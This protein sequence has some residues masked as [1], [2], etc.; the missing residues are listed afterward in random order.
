MFDNSPCGM[1][2]SMALSAILR[3]S[4]AGLLVLLALFAWW[5]ARR[6]A[7][8]QLLSLGIIVGAFVVAGVLAPRLVPTL[9]KLTSFEPGEPLAASWAAA[10]FGALV[11]GAILLRFVTSRLPTPG[12][13]AADR[14]LGG[15]LGVAKGLL[16]GVVVG[17][18]ILG[19]SDRPRSA[20]WSPPAL[21]RPDRPSVAPR[22]AAGSDD[23]GDR[24]RG[25]LSAEGL[26]QG[27]SL[28]ARW[29]QIP[30]WV[31]H[32]VDSVNARITGR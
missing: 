10:L 2:A 9:S 30:P 13:S 5:G 21:S 27:A 32:Q 17:Y 25:S 26:A 6:G 15:L 3:S 1:P 23:L 12:R 11:V 19:T 4:D 20:L 29:F 31:Q 14:W 16:V 28:L 18:A 24:L 7:V 8:R 22:P